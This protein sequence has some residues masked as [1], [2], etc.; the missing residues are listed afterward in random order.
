MQRTSAGFWGLSGLLFASG[1]AALIYEIAWFHQLGLV[2]GTTTISMAILLTSFM[3]G[4][5][6]GSWAFPRLVGPNRHP[7]LVYAGLELL[8]GVFGSISLWSLPALGR[9]YW[10]VAQSG[11][12]DLAVRAIVAGLLLLPPTI[13]LGATL[14]AISRWMECDRDGAARIGWLYG[15]NTLGAVAGSLL[16]G[17]Y[18]LRVHDVVV[19]TWVAVGLNVVIAVVAWSMAPRKFVSTSG[20]AITAGPAPR[21]M[22]DVCLVTGASGLTALGAEVVWTRLMSLVLGPTVYTFS[23]ILAVFLFGLGLGSTFG[24]ALARRVRSPRL[25]LGVTQLLL[26]AAIPFSSHMISGVLPHWVAASPEQTIWS[27]M[28]LDVLHALAV[29]LL[30][31][32]LWG[33]GF[34]LAVASVAGTRH[35]AARLVGRLY[36]ANTLGAIAGTLLVSLV[37]IPLGSGALAERALTLVAGASG[38]LLLASIV[39]DQPPVRESAAEPMPPL[40]PRRKLLP[41]LSL[42]IAA[43]WCGVAVDLVPDTS[44]PLLAWGRNTERWDK[45]AEYRFIREGLNSTILIA[46]SVEGFTCFHVAG[47]IEATNSPSDVRTQRLLGHLPALAHGRPESVL[48]VGCGSG[49]TT[50]SF[51]PYPSVKEIVLCEIEP[52]VVEASRIH[53]A[54]ENH[55][56]LDNPKTRIVYDDARHFLATTDKKFDIITTDPIHPWVRGAA[57]L[58]TVEFFDLC[59]QHLNPG[60][61]IAQWVPLYESNDAAVKCELATI[62]K[63][64]PNASVWSGQGPNEGYDII[65]VGNAE[66]TPIDIDGFRSQMWANPDIVRPLAEAGLGRFSDLRRTYVAQGDDLTAWLQ[67]AEINRDR[68]LRLQFLAGL[69]PAGQ[70]AQGILQTIVRYGQE[71]R[72]LRVRLPFLLAN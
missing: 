61:V 62:L 64:F 13:L 10:T 46:Q 40:A 24:A 49:M 21:G 43:V 27:R 19:A 32:L 29:L 1:C 7:L 57:S 3:G 63:A 31:A 23:I 25:A 9:L 70:S 33:A 5:C 15:L 22:F 72:R 37:L 55:G 26:T 30:P 2:F 59:K 34:P 17:L 14:P 8:V 47:K 28:S 51:L 16:A 69:T 11:S 50:G 39:F 66:G 53:F 18:L 4:M 41:A 60:G 65:L 68:N 36:A 56:V 12:I 58:Y 20:S 71:G 67:D 38:I 42:A 48:I 6:L 35:D 52:A 44:K 54:R 45:V